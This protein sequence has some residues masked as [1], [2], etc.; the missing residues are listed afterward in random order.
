MSDD[1]CMSCGQERLEPPP[2]GCLHKTNHPHYV[3]D[4]EDIGTARWFGESWGAPCCIP[5]AHV[6]TPAG[7]GC[8]Q[9]GADI[10]PGDQGTGCPL[11][12]TD[13]Y[14]WWHLSCW[15][16]SVVGMTP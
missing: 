7:E 8:Q 2:A 15:L 10:E 14:V 11:W 6:D 16:H 12:G 4:D 1:P 13:T 9:C 5:D 3:S